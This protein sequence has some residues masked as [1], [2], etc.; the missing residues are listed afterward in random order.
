MLSEWS[1]GCL[2]GPPRLLSLARQIGPPALE[3]FKDEGFVRL[4]DS[5]QL[6]GLVGG[7]SAQKPMPPAKRRR[8]MHPAKLGC[9]GQAFAFDHRP[10]VV[11]PTLPFVQM[12]HRRLGERIEGAP[13]TLAAEPQQPARASPGDDRSSRTMGQPWLATRSWPLVPKASGR[14]PR[15]APLSVAP[16]A[17][18]VFVS[19]ARLSPPSRFAK[20]A[21]TS[22]RC[23]TR[24]RPSMW[25]NFRV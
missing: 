21:A 9:L 24:S 22:R 14:R 6:S 25:C 20:A 16:P 8:R 1:P 23:S 2:A 4:D 5:A 10:G 3:G 19:P 12:R 15:F 17:A 7:R 18:G 13:A 11:E